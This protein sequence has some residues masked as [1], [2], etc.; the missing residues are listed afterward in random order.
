MMPSDWVVEI[1]ARTD[2]ARYLYTDPVLYCKAPADIERLLAW[3]RALEEDVDALIREQ[4]RRG[5]TISL[6]EAECD[7]L[8]GELVR[9]NRLSR[10]SAIE[11]MR[12]ASGIASAALK[13]AP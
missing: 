12:M 2:F 5:A 11:Y 7:R 8:R 4:V 13:P 3:G 10:Y 1:E 6:L 9:I